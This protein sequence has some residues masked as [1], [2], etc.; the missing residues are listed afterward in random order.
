MKRATE[1]QVEIRPRRLNF[2]PRPREEG[3]HHFSVIKCELVYF[4]PRP[5]EEGDPLTERRYFVKFDFNPRPR[6]EGD[7]FST[8]SNT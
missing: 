6:E 1:Q 7:T 2:N 5:R 8:A 3:D 4:N